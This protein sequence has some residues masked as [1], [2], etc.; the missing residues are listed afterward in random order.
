MQNNSN[1]L[2]IAEYASIAGSIIGTAIAVANQQLLY[3]ATPI[4][5]SLLLNLANRRALERLPR[6]GGSEVVQV[7]RQMLAEMEYMRRSVAE[8]ASGEPVRQAISDLAQ[9][10]SYLQSEMTVQARELRGLQ[11]NLQNL[12]SQRMPSLAP[13]QAQLEELNSRL[14][15]SQP[16][17]NYTAGSSVINSNIETQIE[18]LRIAV[19]GVLDALAKQR[20]DSQSFEFKENLERLFLEIERLQNQ[21]TVLYQMLG[22]LQ[23]SM[24]SA[25][26]IIPQEVLQINE[27][28]DSQNSLN[29][30]TELINQTSSRQLEIIGAAFAQ[31][32]QQLTQQKLSF[33][34]NY[35]SKSAFDFN[36]LEAALVLLSDGVAAVS[37]TLQSRIIESFQNPVLQQLEE[38]KTA[39]EQLQKS[40]EIEPNN[41]TQIVDLSEIEAALAKL[42]MPATVSSPIDLSE[43][44]ATLSQVSNDILSIPKDILQ[45]FQTATESTDLT[46]IREGIIKLRNQMIDLQES[47]D[48]SRENQTVET[49]KKIEPEGINLEEEKEEIYEE[50]EIEQSSINTTYAQPF[51][52][53]NW[54]LTNILRGHKSAVTCLNINS[55]GKILASGSCKEVKL[56]N[57]ETGTELHNFDIDS[58]A[59]AIADLA[60]HPDGELLAVANA[61]IELWNL[62]TQEKTRTLETSFWASCVTISADGKI[63]VSAGEDPVDE[64]GSIQIWKLPKAELLHDLGPDVIYAVAIS[65]K[66]DILVTGGMISSAEDETEKEGLIQLRRLPSGEVFHTIKETSKVYAVAISSDGNNLVTGGEDGKVK[67]WYLPTGQLLRK[68]EGHPSPV[69]SIAISP[70]G[71]IIATGSSDTTV[72]LWEMHTGALL[73]IL[74]EHTE[75]VS[76]VAFSPDGKTLVSAS[77][78]MSVKVCRCG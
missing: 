30:L 44:K 25:G 58:D 13:V 7:Q 48:N 32:Q 60:I 37:G 33:E 16:A 2:I 1:W 11:N 38:I 22:L 39:L 36:R 71:E 65:P 68:L 45:N 64:T 73:Q 42:Q 29:Q 5:L 24:G 74:D 27:F 50:K 47:F 53:T 70:D 63:M 75:K 76:K 34:E 67:V 8:T 14:I 20:Q 62:R 41:K 26:E 61:N 4:S 78:D 72:K 6:G 3:A 57:L 69:H 46:A 52:K 15:K 43:V 18:E 23:N 19:L 10:M 54:R 49:R 59:M 31:L 12:A 51:N 21:Q 40:S 66:G 28:A 55:A 77:S 56:W 9:A 17:N 35:I